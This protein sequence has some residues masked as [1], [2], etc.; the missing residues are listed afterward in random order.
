MTREPEIGFFRDPVKKTSEF[1]R[2]LQMLLK[3]AVMSVWVVV[4]YT[5]SWY[6]SHTSNLTVKGYSFE[7]TVFMLLIIGLSVVSAAPLLHS[8]TQ[9]RILYLAAASMLMLFSSAVSVGLMP[10]DAEKVVT[11]V[12]S[13]V[14]NVRRTA[15]WQVEGDIARA[16]AALRNRK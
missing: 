2:S 6:F 15:E 13:H 4:A 1:V 5:F 14:F 12:D 16:R 7:E 11:Y 8:G 3:L 10:Y 9:D